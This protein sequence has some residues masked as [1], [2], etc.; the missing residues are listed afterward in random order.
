MPTYCYE[1]NDCDQTWNTFHGID[2][3]EEKCCF[4]LSEKIKKSFRSMVN[5]IKPDR[6][7]YPE[8]KQQIR[9]RVEKHFIVGDMVIL[10]THNLVI[11]NQPTHKFKQRYI[12][13]Y[14]IVKVLSPTSYELQLPGT[15]NVHPIFHI[16]KLKSSLNRGVQRAGG[17]RI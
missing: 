13:P 3:K 4:C 12:G 5:N 16:S 11:R 1:C 6:F 15:M 7:L 8:D 9:N 14:P 10:D 2:E 17:E